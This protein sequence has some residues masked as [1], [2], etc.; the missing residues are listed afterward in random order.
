MLAVGEQVFAHVQ[1]LLQAEPRRPALLQVIL[2]V[3]SEASEISQ[4]VGALLKTAA[5]EDPAFSGQVLAL[6]VAASAAEIAQVSEDNARSSEPVETEVRYA[7]GVRQVLVWQ[8]SASPRDGARP[9]VPWKDGGV[10]WITGGAGGLGL[11]FAREIA[12]RTKG[13]TIILSGRSSL[14]DAKR[15]ALETCAQSGARV[16]YRVVDV[17]DRRAVTELVQSL[18]REHGALHGILH[19]AGVIR[20]NFVVRKDIRE[21]REVLA[22]KVR[23]TCYLDVATRELDL[24]FLILFSSVSAVLG[25]V[26]Q[27]DYAMANA[28]MDGYAARRNEWLRANGRSGRTLAINWPLWAEGGMRVSGALEVEMRR[29][30][31]DYLETAAGIESLYRAWASE[32]AQVAVLAVDH[33]KLRQRLGI[34]A[35]PRDAHVPAAAPVGAEDRAL[36]TAEVDTGDLL[37]RVQGALAAM[38]SRDMKVAIEEIQPNNE[39]TALGFDSVGFMVFSKALNG[40]YGLALSPTVFFEYPTLHSFAEFL[41]EQHGPQLAAQLAAPAAAK[42]EV[43]QPRAARAAPVALRD[44]RPARSR[45]DV[46]R[47]AP[48]PAPTEDDPIAIIGMSGCFPGADGVD[49]FWQNL[50]AERDCIVE[51]PASR[52]D[53]QA[54]YGDPTQETNKTNV[55]WGGFMAGIDEFDPLFFG[56]APTEAE[57]M[58]PAQ[59]LLMMHTWKVIEDAGYSAHSLS[60]TKTAIFVGTGTSGYTELISGANVPIEGHSSTGAVASL[61]PN[62]MSYLLNLH[63]PSEPIETACSS[64]LVAIHRALRAMQSGDCEMALVGGVNVIPT[65]WAHISFS[66]AGMLCEDGRCKTFSKHANGYVRGE[67]VG[68]LFLKKLSAAERDGDHIYALIRGSAENHGGRASSLTAPNPKAQAEVIKAAYREA[69]IDPRTVTYIETHG[70]G[71]ALG[72]PIEIN[73]LKSAFGELHRDAAPDAALSGNAYCGI[74]SVKTNIGHLELAAGVAGVIKVVMQLRHRTLVKSLHCEEINPYIDLAGSPFYIVRETQPWN[75]PHDRHGRALPRRAGVS[76]FGFGGV[77]AHVV[78][79]EYRGPQAP[80]AA[81]ALDR[82][83]IIVLSAKN[84]ERLRDYARQ[85]LAHLDVRACSPHDL[86]SIAYTLQVGREAMEHRLALLANDGDELRAKLA[87]YLEGPERGALDG[88]WVGQVRRDKD[89]LAVFDADDDLQEAVGKWLRRGK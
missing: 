86:A 40:I 36:P 68:M 22:P 23:G 34:G 54:I 82:P 69:K 1:S 29:Q 25:N 6:P 48:R 2:A 24:D 76:S 13:A 43:A 72:D 14:D 89:T 53:W 20:D 17:T 26:G 74:G 56:I 51:V 73:G 52:W 62:R 8:A 77:N 85:L 79:E 46:V 87:A 83:A 88:C 30:G 49:A 63:G 35:G 55:K 78:L 19:S 67:G 41:V 37:A 15:A 31:F 84:Q 4:G 81:S 32:A 39:L 59:R 71:T 60:G 11:I 7:D 50:A 18:V 61:G 75:T 12:A 16:E 10:Y 44:G 3:G 58:D 70:T 45:A 9:A 57:L 47:Q 33:V 28:F 66:R 21:L 64:S 5:Q 42:L 27:A 38:I 80:P 65:S